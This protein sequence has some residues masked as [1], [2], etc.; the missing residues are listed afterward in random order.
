MLV[1]WHAQQRGDYVH[2]LC[3]YS[4]QTNKSYGLE[5]YGYLPKLFMHIYRSAS[6]SLTVSWI[7]LVNQI[8]LS[9]LSATLASSVINEKNRPKLDTRD[10]VQKKKMSITILTW[11]KRHHKECPLF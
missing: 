6:N 1:S 7:Q 8:N 10:H 4:T 11:L 5:H 3:P 2:P 9:M